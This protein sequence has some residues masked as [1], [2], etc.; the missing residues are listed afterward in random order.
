MKETVKILRFNPE[1]DEKPY[2]Q[3]FEYE[4][5][6]GI[7]VL[8]VLNYIYENIDPT[9]SYSYCCRNGHCGVCGIMVNGKA[10]LSCKTAVSPDIIIEPLRNIKVIKDLVIE[11]DE[12]EKRFPK[13]RLFLERQCEPEYEPEKIEMADFEKFKFVSRCVECL[14]CV[15]VCPEFRKNP[16]LFAGPL[17]FVLEARHI[18]DPRDELNRTLLLKTQGIDKCIECGLCSKV[19]MH[20]VDPASTIKQIK[21]IKEII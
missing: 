13:L 1:A 12:Y 11:R 5:K 15:S 18:F 2:Y 19:C 8:D 3:N 20:N 16:H 21:N 4:Y 14:L 10:V 9:L 17:A 7:T 6:A